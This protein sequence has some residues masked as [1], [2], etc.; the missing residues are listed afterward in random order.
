[1]SW[2]VEGTRKTIAR[3]FGP[4]QLELAQ[5]CLRSLYDRQ[6]YAR[7]HYQRAE[8]TLMRYVRSHLKEKD[9]LPIAFG[10]DELEWNRF[11]VVIRKVGADLA[12]CV[13]S[14]HAIPDILASAAYYALALDRTAKPEKGRYVN[15]AF[16][17]KSIKTYVPLT[18]VHRALQSATTG[19][20]YR[21]LAGLANQSKHYSI[22][23]P[24]LSHDLT[25]ARA[26]QYLLK[27]PAF[28]ARGIPHSQVFVKDFLPPIHDQISRSVVE[29]GRAIDEYLKSASLRL[30]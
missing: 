7:F 19:E 10:A 18:D 3:V 8:T 22:V 6:F 14:L 9:F 21:Q 1:M 11:N 24:E 17:T 25:G 16:V 29:T 28:N 15:H 20:R 23:F 2:Y 4:E 30:G 27:F 13:Q 26:E 12:A 5:P